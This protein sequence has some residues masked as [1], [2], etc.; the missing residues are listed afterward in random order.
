MDIFIFTST[1]VAQPPSAATMV[2]IRR[3]FLA[4]SPENCRQGFTGGNMQIHYHGRHA[5]STYSACSSLSPILPSPSM[6]LQPETIGHGKSN[7]RVRMW[8]PT[9]IIGHK[10]GTVAYISF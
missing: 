5:L 1:I 4:S 3:L 8:I 10:N 7:R 6:L 2:H 9:Y